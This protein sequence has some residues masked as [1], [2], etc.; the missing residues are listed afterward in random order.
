[1]LI[2]KVIKNILIGSNSF[3]NR[4]TVDNQKH[5]VEVVKII[6]QLK[7]KKILSLQLEAAT[8][9]VL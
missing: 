3:L 2:A 8:G 4:K 1:M 5:A 7:W 9:G 6:L